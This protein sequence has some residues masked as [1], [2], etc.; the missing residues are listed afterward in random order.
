MFAV[1]GLGIAAGCIVFAS[2]TRVP[3]FADDYA[4][5]ARVQTPGWW[6]S[7]AI[8]DPAGTFFTH[9]FRP[10]LFLWFGFV[11][12]LFGLHP[13]PMHIATGF[14]VFAG[15][16]LTGLVAWRLGLRCGA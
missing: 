2:A 15:A 16:V 11:H 10:G 9:H 3:L 5:L 1:A 8:W 13:V 12:G 6:H 14:I 7:S 4:Y